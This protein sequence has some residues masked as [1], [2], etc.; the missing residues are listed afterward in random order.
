MWHHHK[1]DRRPAPAESRNT[2]NLARP[3]GTRPSRA[4][5]ATAVIAAAGSGLRLGAG[6]PKAFVDVG[7]RPLW[8][9]S[10]SAMREAVTVG[11]VIVAA[12]AGHR[13]DGVRTV[14]G[15]ETR[16]ESVAAA[17]AEVGTELVVIHDA[18][19]P[20]VTSA[21]VDRVVRMLEGSGADGV[22][23]ATPVADTLK[24]AEEGGEIARTVD[25]SGLWAAQ[26]PQA[27]RTEALRAAQV[28]GDLAGATDEA[29]LIEAAGGR[30]L[31]ERVDEPNLKVT[32]SA[33]I[34]I[35]AAL[36]SDQARA[37]AAQRTVGGD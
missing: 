23:A 24:E 20:L 15:G 1:G 4:P 12:P 17:L 25:R 9:W 32:T 2:E 3:D 6:G 33:D 22:I 21:L 16:A 10:L 27:F 30:V 28:A 7:G 19:R 29:R 5:R 35:A 26:T 8:E 34:R 13:I 31:L 14:A 37:C 36:L 18:A 11:D